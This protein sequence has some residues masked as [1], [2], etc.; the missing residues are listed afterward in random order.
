MISPLKDYQVGYDPETERFVVTLQFAG[1]RL[2][3]QADE[4]KLSGFAQIIQ[5]A[6]KNKETRDEKSI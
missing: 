3:F 2:I 5:I 6:I 4:S 1:I